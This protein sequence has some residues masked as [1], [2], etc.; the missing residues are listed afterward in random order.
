M[1]P[2]VEFPLFTYLVHRGSILLFQMVQLLLVV[3][4]KVMAKKLD[5][6]T[7]G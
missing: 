5:A 2:A 4:L 1:F 7:T 3:V 6:R